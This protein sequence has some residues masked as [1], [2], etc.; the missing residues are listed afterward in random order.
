MTRRRPTAA[1]V[2]FALLVLAT[3]AAFA[4]AQQKK[5]DPLIVDRVEL[6]NTR[7]TF[8]P[9]GASCKKRRL[10]IKFR[11][12]TSNDATIEVVRQP[13][14]ELVRTLA[15]ERFLKRY[16]YHLLAWNGVD[17]AGELAAAGRYR[18]RVL[19][20]DEARTL[21]LPGTIRLHLKPA[22]RPAVCVNVK[23]NPLKGPG[24]GKSN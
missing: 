11:T 6:G 2:V 3:V 15:R 17:D 13:G 9:R 12:T 5:R 23:D 20:E 1:A 7:H 16:S 21:V 4:Y 10:R 24:G 19:L 18:L 22:R 8:N 14:G